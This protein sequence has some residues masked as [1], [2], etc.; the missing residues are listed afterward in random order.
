MRPWGSGNS[1]WG[2]PAPLRIGSLSR[3]A[4]LGIRQLGLGYISTSQDQES[5]QIRVPGDMASRI[6][7]YQHLPGSGVSEQI[8]VP[9]DQATRIGVYQHL[10]GSGVSEQIRVPWDSATRIGLYQHLP[11][12]GVSEQI[13]VPGDQATRIG[14]YQHL[15]G[16]GLRANTRPWGHGNSSSNPATLQHTGEL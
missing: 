5:Q 1:D 3:Y 9:G 13:R 4:S 14:V 6:G 11:G 12:S 10:S 16:S 2:I 8:R 15:S 7:V